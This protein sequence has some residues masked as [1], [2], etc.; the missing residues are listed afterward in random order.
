ML[1]LITDRTAQDVARLQTLNA[2]G[3]DNMSDAEKAEWR[4]AS[5]G[6]YNYSDL[7]RVEN[8]VKYLG[9]LLNENHFPVELL[10]VRTWNA[11]DVPT[12]TDMTRYLENI[13]RI[14]EAFVTLTTTP[15][16]PAS[17]RNLTYVEANDIEQILADVDRLMGNMLSTYYHCGEVFGGELY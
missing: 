7:N 4:T 17:M 2:K 3:W 12:L 15:Q 1:E 9:E 13:R 16:V 8:A 11:A 6:A 5:K 14:R 10:E